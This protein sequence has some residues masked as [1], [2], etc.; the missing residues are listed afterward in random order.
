M[1]FKTSASDLQYHSTDNYEM[2]NLVDS[3]IQPC[4]PRCAYRSN[5]TRIDTGI[6][7]FILTM[8]VLVL[9][10][11]KLLTI[12]GFS[13]IFIIMAMVTWM[14]IILTLILSVHLASPEIAN[15]LYNVSGNIFTTSVLTWVLINLIIVIRDIISVTRIA[16]TLN[17]VVE[18]TLAT[19][20]FSWIIVNISLM[21]W[22][23]RVMT[24]CV[25]CD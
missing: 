21:I 12:T 2:Y 6:I 5:S 10:T 24:L 15:L 14:F 23:I 16:S 9:K 4:D 22:I 20:W 11:L 13:K 25:M 1:S 8:I 19:S 17:Y 7:W 18:K 3:K